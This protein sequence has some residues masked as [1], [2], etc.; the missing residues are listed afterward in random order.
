MYD[1]N[2]CDSGEYNDDD[3]KR[4]HWPQVVSA[5]VVACLF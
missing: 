5:V 4:Q 2:E 1:E 3:E